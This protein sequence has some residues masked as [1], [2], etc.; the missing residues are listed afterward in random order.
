MFRKVMMLLGMNS[1]TM[2]QNLAQYGN[3]VDIQQAIDRGD[4]KALSFIEKA[5]R[6]IQQRNPQLYSQVQQMANGWQQQQF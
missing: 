6:D 5:A 4:T 3:P 2:A 1:A